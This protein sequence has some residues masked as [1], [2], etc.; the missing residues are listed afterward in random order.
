MTDFLA[1]LGLVLVLEGIAF[2]AFPGHVRR[3]MAQ[4]AETP[5]DM[6]RI[7][8]IV[9]AILGLAVVWVVRNLLN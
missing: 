4:A 1:A 2:A 3:A 9:S 8:G 7:I 5:P 6:L